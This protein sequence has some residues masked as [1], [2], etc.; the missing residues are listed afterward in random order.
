MAK[1]KAS[2]S[3]II[4]GGGAAGAATANALKNTGVSVTI[5]DRQNYL[6]WS[7]AAARSLVA[8][9]EIEKKSFTMPLKEVSQFYDAKFVHS[10][11]TNIGEKSVQLE[12]GSTMEADCIVIAVGGHYDS[13]AI[14][15]PTPD[16]TTKES[17]IKCFRAEHARALGAKSIA[18][19]GAGLAGVEIA[20]ELK[21]AFPEKKITLVGKL[22]PSVTATNRKR[23]QAGLDKLG[24][25]LVQGRLEQQET[26][27][28]KATTSLGETI[29]ADIIY[30]AA[31][32]IFSVQDIL[33]SEL[34]SS[35]AKTGQ[36]NCK[37]TLQLETC[38]SIFACGDIVSIP[39]GKFA[40]VKGMMHA[41]E[42]A[43]T[44][45]E[46][47]VNLLSGKPLSA[48]KWSDKPINMPVMTVLGPNVAVCALGMP[49]FMKGV[50]NMLGKKLKG[51]DFFL[52]MKAK[53]YGKG[54]TW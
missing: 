18:V 19:A 34:K 13:G 30:D 5:V 15:K 27:N 49:G 23:V 38:G 47:V 41:E 8:P 6:D 10:A 1:K 33:D 17:R 14:W 3:C 24:V 26:V 44:V 48:F 2:G 11:V 35:V 12:N 40:D 36:L 52:S 20:G 54:K 28:G 31:G 50:E 21:A 7:I 16:Q 37:P 45:A 4:I 46:N 32:F 39:E 22:L 53:E 9:D 42:T 29:D 51:K 25:V 43:K